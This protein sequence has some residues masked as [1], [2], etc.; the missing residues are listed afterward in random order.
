M[1]LHKQTL[2]T[3]D[4]TSNKMDEQSPPHTH[5][6][7]KEVASNTQKVFFATVACF[8]VCLLTSFS[9]PPPFSF[10]AGILSILQDPP[11]PPP[12][13][14][15]PATPTHPPSFPCLAVSR[16]STYFFVTLQKRKINNNDRLLR[17]PHHHQP[18]HPILSL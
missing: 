4:K 12:Y 10:F 11:H 17:I 9:S 2:H 13:P 6:L 5:T 8:H 16:C 15:S 18:P 1:K 7:E 14:R 3:K